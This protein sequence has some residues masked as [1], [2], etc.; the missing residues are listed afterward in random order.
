MFACEL[1]KLIDSM[2]VLCK[3]R[4]QKLRVRLSEVVPF[5]SRVL[6]DRTRQQPAAKCTVGQRCDSVHPAPGDDLL[7]GFPFEEVERRLR[8]GQWRDTTKLFHR[9]DGIVGDA[10]RSN[11]SRTLDVE[12][13]LGGL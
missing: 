8:G 7:H 10:D 2:G 5:K 3:A 11:L 1:L 13:R 12:Q 6:S 4:R 9:L